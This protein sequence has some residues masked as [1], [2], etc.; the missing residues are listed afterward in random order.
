MPNVG[1]TY[2]YA[3]GRLTLREGRGMAT[4]CDP[5][6]DG[7]YDLRWNPS[8]AGFSLGQVSETCASRGMTLNGLAFTP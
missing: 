6:G 7:A 4:G 2:S 8:C 1:G 5:T 3:G